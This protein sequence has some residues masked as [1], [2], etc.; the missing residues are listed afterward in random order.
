MAGGVRSGGRVQRGAGPQRTCVACRRVQPQPGLI[1]VVR[2]A[3]GLLEVDDGRGRAGRGAYLCRRLQCLNE[4][5]R[6]SRWAQAFRAPT[7]T[8]PEVM[9]RLR[10]LLD[11]NVRVA[12]PP[13]PVEGRS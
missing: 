13:V 3:A 8:T 10:R 6:R 9:E 5:T 4:S 2:T 12:P 11:E 7:V 1:R